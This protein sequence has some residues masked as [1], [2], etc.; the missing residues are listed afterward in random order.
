[1]MQRSMKRELGLMCV[2]LRA[3]VVLSGLVVFG[4]ISAS[5]PSRAEDYPVR[6]VR[7]IVPFA[8]GGPADIYGRVVAQ[9]LSESLKQ[10]FVVED[11]PG[12]GSIVGSEAAARATPDGYTLLVISNTHTANESLFS[13]KPFQLMRD[14]VPIAPINYSD[15][16]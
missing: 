16:V 12:S 11:R 13:T 2:L 15:L 4:A 3:M 6:P 8:A 1:V 5:A 9:Y 10:P 7:I 14:F